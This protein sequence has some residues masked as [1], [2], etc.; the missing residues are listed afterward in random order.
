MMRLPF[1]DFSLAILPKGQVKSNRKLDRM[2]MELNKGFPEQMLG[3]CSVKA[4]LRKPL[5]LVFV[6]L[7]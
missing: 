6:F 5:S 2:E 7:V 4:T 1:G 3:L